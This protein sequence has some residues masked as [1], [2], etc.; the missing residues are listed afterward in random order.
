[1]LNEE[2]IK[3]ITNDRIEDEAIVKKLCIGLRTIEQALT[4]L[5][6][7]I[8]GR[9]P[10][11]FEE[12]AINKIEEYS[13]ISDFIKQDIESAYGQLKELQSF[14]PESNIK[15]V[16]NADSA[17]ELYILDIKA[18]SCCGVELE[19]KYTTVY[20]FNSDGIVERSKNVWTRYCHICGRHYVYPDMANVLKSS[21]GD[22]IH[23]NTAI[24]YTPVIAA[25]P[26]FIDITVIDKT[27]LCPICGADLVRE[28][29]SYHVYNDTDLMNFKKNYKLFSMRCSK[30][31][32]LFITTGTYSSVERQGII[33]Y[34]NLKFNFLQ[35]DIKHIKA[36][37][38]I[39][40]G[41]LK[42]NSAGHMVEC[43][44][45]TVKSIDNKDVQININYCKNCNK[46]YISET[47]L[48]SYQTLY[49]VLL[50]NRKPDSSMI[51]YFDSYGRSSKSPL[52]IHG[53][54][55]KEGVL[56]VMQRQCILASIIGNGWM[57]K[58]KVMEY[59]EIFISTNGE[60]SKN[61]NAREKWTEDL[62]F[63]QNYNKENQDYIH[64][65]LRQYVASKQC[66]IEP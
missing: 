37:V 20:I 49:G 55:V 63:V 6:L 60:S 61:I 15:S 42:C 54:T 26:Q 4:N 48:E 38:Y 35:S 21:F 56:S 18:K 19:D 41:L 51:E 66:S 40:R 57:T 53:Y 59:L 14:F 25:K 11:L 44:I 46:Y 10:T 33:K 22:N 36:I 32:R 52:R 24:D 34:C 65:E 2:L 16:R 13:N 50:F 45:A 47:S 30:C 29:L 31:N 23:F 5:D 28:Q 62:R 27:R 17:S 7:Y 3:F 1:M 43:V 64:A 12:K 39:Y 58:S 9:V 8:I